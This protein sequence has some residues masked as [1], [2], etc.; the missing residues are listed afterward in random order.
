[1]TDRMQLPPAHAFLACGQL[2]GRETNLAR[3]EMASTS[4]GIGLIPIGGSL[5]STKLIM[6]AVEAIV[7]YFDD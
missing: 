2:Q 4:G 6:M 5:V 7:D 1:M 3:R